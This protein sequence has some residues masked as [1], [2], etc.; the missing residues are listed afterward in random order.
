MN[1]NTFR[2]IFTSNLNV[3]HNPQEYLLNV[4][5][6]LSQNTDFKNVPTL[7]NYMGFVRGLG[8]PLAASVIT[9]VNPT[10]VVQIQ[11]QYQNKNFSTLLTESAV[12]TQAIFTKELAKNDLKYE[13]KAVNSVADR[14]KGF[15]LQPRYIREL[16]V[17]AYLSSLLPSNIQYVTDPAVPIYK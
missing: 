12:L 16:C 14:R 15:L 10:M 2:C 9:Q 7:I 1:E 3:A 8:Q 6:L 4:K 13:L 5:E 17:L 11:S